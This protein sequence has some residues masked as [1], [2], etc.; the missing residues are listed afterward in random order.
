MQNHRYEIALPFRSD[1]PCLPSN[2]ALA[3]KR[4]EQLKRKLQKNATF[5]MEY[6]RQIHKLLVNGY[7]EPAL[8]NSH[9]KAGRVWY[10]PHHGVTHPVK[11]DKLRVVFDCAFQCEGTSLNDELLQGPDLTKSLTAVL[12]RFRKESVA[13]MADIEGMFLQVK[14]PEIQRDFLRFLWWPDG[15]IHTEPKEYRMTVHLFWSNLVT[16]LCQFC[17]APHC[18]RS[19]TIVR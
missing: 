11:N 13:F 1:N 6:T 14:V 19:W 10:L 3:H 5:A 15:D 2:K 8:D 4:L 12:I 18:Y 7:A 9:D 16:Q 17:S